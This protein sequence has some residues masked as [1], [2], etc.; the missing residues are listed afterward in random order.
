[1]EQEEKTDNNR[2]MQKV[3]VTKLYVRFKAIV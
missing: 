1:M 3:P 2:E